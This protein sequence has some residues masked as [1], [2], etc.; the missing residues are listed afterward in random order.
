M[1]VLEVLGAAIPLPTE[2]TVTNAEQGFPGIQG[3]TA[4][5][6]HEAIARIQAVIPGLVARGDVRRQSSR[7]RRADEQTMTQ[8][9][10]GNATGLVQS[11][12]AEKALHERVGPIQQHDGTGL[13]Q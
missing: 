3:N 13:I 2:G 1:V 9:V 10:L 11:R 4:V 12:R 7:R 6:E 5:P 8:H